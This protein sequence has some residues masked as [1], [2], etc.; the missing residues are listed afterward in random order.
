M[1]SL[2]NPYVNLATQSSHQLLLLLLYY[3]YYY[4]Y[5]Y[6]CCYCVVVNYNLYNKPP[7]GSTPV[8][9]GYLLLRHSCTWEKTSI[10]WSCQVFG[11]VAGEVNSCTNY[12]IYFIFYFLFSLFLYL[13]LFLF[14]CF[15]FYCFSFLSFILF[16]HVHES[17]V[18]YIKWMTL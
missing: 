12:S 1:L 15:F 13:T 4:Y 8:L 9:P 2:F 17:V 14:F 11:A 5:Y 18:T 3:F 16:L 6:C 10:F 7:C